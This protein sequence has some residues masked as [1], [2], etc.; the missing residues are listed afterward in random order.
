TTSKAA[1]AASRTTLLCS[2]IPYR[3]FA[4]VVLMWASD[5][6]ALLSPKVPL[7]STSSAASPPISL[8]PTEAPERRHPLATMK[9]TTTQK[10]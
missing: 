3:L 4:A 10:S 2:M 5:G 6:Q 8:P 1:A 9:A 7:G